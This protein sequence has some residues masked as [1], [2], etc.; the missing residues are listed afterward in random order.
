MATTT[1]TLTPRVLVAA[2][3]S[4]PAGLTNYTRSTPLDMKGRHG[5]LLS[6]RIKN[7]T[8]PTTQLE[9]RVFIAHNSGATPAAP[10]A[11]SSALGTAD[12]HQHFT[13]GGGIVLNALTEQT[14]VLP[15]CCSVLI[16]F[17]GN[18]GNAV[19]CEAFLTE[20][21]DLQTA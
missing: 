11:G 8:A 3:S 21:T 6:M 18:T 17:T 20:Y 9:G 19:T 7:G 5:G 16:E 14:I 15:P 10:A 13:F 4:N 12:W 1:T 2:S